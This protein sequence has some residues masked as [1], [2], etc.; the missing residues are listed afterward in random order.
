MR[1]AEFVELRGRPG[2]E[3][4][5][6]SFDQPVAGGDPPQLRVNLLGA[7]ATVAFDL[8]NAAGT[9]LQS[10][11]L[12]AD[13][14][15]VGLTSVYQGAVSL[16]AEAFWIRAAGTTTSGST[17]S[18]L[19]RRFS[20]VPFGIQM[21]LATLEVTPGQTITIPLVLTNTGAPRTLRVVL[22]DSTGL[23]GALPTIPDQQVSTNATVP[24]ELT[25]PQA[26]VPSK[27]TKITAT[28]S[29]VLE[30]NTANSNSMDV[31]VTRE[32]P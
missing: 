14:S 27:S 2:H 13:P 18:V 1:K 32:I 3:G 22:S 29:D 17:F 21:P 6:K 16:P 4:W 5:F 31:E 8:V 30:S 19:S 24:F 11:A 12:E 20:A 26:I 25:V 9:S 15:G 28:V 10:A 23:L 7:V